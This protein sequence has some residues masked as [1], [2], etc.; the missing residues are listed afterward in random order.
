MAPSYEIDSHD[1]EST[2]SAASQG[3]SVPSLSLQPDLNPPASNYEHEN[4]WYRKFHPDYSITEQ[5]V[6]APRPIRLVI[7]GAGAAGLNIAYKALR[8]FPPGAI[9]FSIYEKNDD[10]GGTWL[11]NRY[12]GCQC[13]IPSHAYQWSFA[14]KSDWTSYYSAAEE[15][16]HYLKDWSDQNGL[17]ELVK[18][19][20]RVQKAQWSEEEGVWKVEGGDRDGVT[21]KDEGNVLASC[22]GALK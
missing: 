18:F 15:I 12:P 8:Q 19:G 4:E 6:H 5:P 1:E 22:H 20:H 16:W 11:E 14:R 7:I 9:S 21:F 17:T 3:K 10:V 2:W 13:D